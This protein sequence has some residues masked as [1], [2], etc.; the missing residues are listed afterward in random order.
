MMYNLETH[1][2][3]SIENYVHRQ[4]SDVRAVRLSPK[5]GAVV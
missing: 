1:E 5:V 2:Q 4:S 3:S